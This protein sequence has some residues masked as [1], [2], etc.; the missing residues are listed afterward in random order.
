MQFGALPPIEGRR[1]AQEAATKALE[2]DGA[3]AEAY[4]ALGYVKHYNWDWADA[5]QDFKRAIE[6]N[7]NYANAHNFYASL[8]DVARAC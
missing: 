8:F 1:R 6:L 3:L 7:P 4:N 5:E 2:L